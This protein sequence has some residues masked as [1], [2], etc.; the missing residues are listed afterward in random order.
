MLLQVLFSL[1]VYL[2]WPYARRYIHRASTLA[3][4]CLTLLMSLAAAALLWPLS[5]VLA[6]LLVITLALVIVVCPWWLVSSHKFK[7][8][9]N[10]PWDEAVPHIPHELQR[11]A[12]L[13]AT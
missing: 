4:A 13:H 7:A 12:S 10:G 6:A 8:K 9:I 5:P 1:E 3:H 2:L 11:G